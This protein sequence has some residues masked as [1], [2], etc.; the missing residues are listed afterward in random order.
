ML[1]CEVEEGSPVFRLERMAPRP[2]EVAQLAV[3]ELSVGRKAGSGEIA[4]AQELVNRR[5]GTQHLELALGIDPGVVSPVCEQHGAGRAQRHQAMLIE[6][7]PVGVIIELLEPCVEP[8]RES[9]VDLFD[10]LG[11]FAR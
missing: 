3:D 6:R 8:V 10:S 5:C 1:V 9:I 4:G 7:E 2:E 11:G